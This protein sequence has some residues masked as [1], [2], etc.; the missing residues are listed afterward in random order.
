MPCPTDN[1]RS[2]A[3]TVVQL[4]A[5]ELP[6]MSM[7]VL[8][9]GMKLY[10]YDRCDA[11]VVYLT[12]L[13]EGGIA[14]SGVPAIAALS[15]IMQREGSGGYDGTTISSVLDYNGA[16]IKSDAT[17][18]HLRHSLYALT[19]R[20]DEVIPIFAD[21]VF[22]PTMPEAALAVRRE[23]L[24][25]NIEVSDENVEYLAKCESDKL[26]MGPDHPLAITDTP[27]SIRAIT[28][29]DLTGFRGKYTHAAG[30]SIFICGKLDKG[31]IACITDTLQAIAPGGANPD[32]DI[33]HF[34]PE[35]AG[36]R[37]A[38][39][40]AHA[41]Q[42][43][44]VLTLPAIPRNHP[45]YI[46]LHLCVYALGGYFGSRLMLNVREK[47]GLTY[48]I[49]ASMPGYIDGAYIEI[50]AETDNRHVGRLVEEV[51]KELKDLA[52]NPCRGD[53]LIRLRQSAISTHAA[54]TDSPLSITDHY[55][56]AL[57]QGLPAGYFEAKQKAIAA[58]T[59]DT[60]AEMA[61]RYLN[62]DRLR[63]TVA[64]NPD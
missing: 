26:I 18:H 19:L 55:I 6:Q 42:S 51:R 50:S 1:F 40:R 25:R 47:E 27:E 5:V 56:T 13:N 14:E 49:S 23:G 24:A 52:A 15:A 44:V 64:G 39:R 10:V 22:R 31:A 45:D 12:V 8:E 53:E 20:I 62:P 21:M 41:S 48:G 32:P 33:R 60:I 36:Q 59:P 2:K 28:S 57:T 9:N 17:S 34:T 4:P 61:Q 7:S 43:A 46:P 11:P 35:A 58:L 54:I 3:P 63:I 30:T 16:W 37:P 38:I 29:D